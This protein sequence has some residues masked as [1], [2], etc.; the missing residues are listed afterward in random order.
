MNL[1]SDYVELQVTS[2]FSFLEGAAHPEEL[3]ARAAE[4]GHPAVAITDRNT[5]AGVVRGHLGAKQAEIRIIVGTRLD[6]MDDSP[7]L[8]CLPTNKAAY[9]RLSQLLTLGK[10]RAA[11]AQCHLTIADLT[12]P[13]GG[14]MLGAGQILIALPPDDLPENSEGIF[15][16]ERT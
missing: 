9:A 7:S 14:F 4:L 12:N 16:I 11:K 2:N 15:S 6:F 3:A 10:R 8:L 13:D 1:N 5:L